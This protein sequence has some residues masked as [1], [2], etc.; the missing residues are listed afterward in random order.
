MNAIAD[1]LRGAGVVNF[2]MP[3][4]PFRVWSALDAAVR[5]YER[6]LGGV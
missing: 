3:A 2:D 5:V 1:A 4:T 6:S